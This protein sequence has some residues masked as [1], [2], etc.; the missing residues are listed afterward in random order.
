[1]G[2]GRLDKRAF[3]H[4]RYQPGGI[5]VEKRGSAA[6]AALPSLEQTGLSL[7]AQ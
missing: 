1:M 2:R 3:T 4:C 6:A 7:D 5:G